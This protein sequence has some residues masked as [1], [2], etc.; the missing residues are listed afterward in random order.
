MDAD[1]GL[2]GLRK[3]FSGF[4]LKF[5]IPKGKSLVYLF[6]A[7]VCHSF[8]IYINFKLLNI[9]VSHKCDKNLYFVNLI[10]A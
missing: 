2:S 1:Y 3:R 6:K 8:T 9:N 4:T 10:P 5:Y 7:I